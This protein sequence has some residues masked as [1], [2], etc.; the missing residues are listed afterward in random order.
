MIHEFVLHNKGNDMPYL[1]VIVDKNTYQVIELKN[2]AITIGRDMNNDIVSKNGTVSLYH[3]RVFCD[4]SDW[5]IEDLGSAGGFSVNGHRKFIT[6]LY[7]NDSIDIG[8]FRGLR[9]LY[10]ENLGKNEEIKKKIVI[11]RDK[12]HKVDCEEFKAHEYLIEPD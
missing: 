10:V 6:K 12:K 2:K 8:G 5:I 11:E 1:K 4:I 3:C 7:D 9:I